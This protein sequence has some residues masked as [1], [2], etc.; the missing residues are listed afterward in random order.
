[1]TDYWKP[2]ISRLLW[3][4]MAGL[5]LAVMS[6]YWLPS[7][8]LVMAGYIGWTLFKLRQL[9]RWLTHGQKAEE[10]PDSDGAWEQ[11]AYLIHKAQQKSS[12]RK[13]QQMD[14]LMRFNNVL[15]ALP[16][17]A[18][19]LDDQNHIQWV[20][21]SASLL[22]GIHEK[23]D[24]QQRI[25]NLLRHPE[26]HKGLAE[27][28]EREIRFTAP[29]DENITLMAR[30]LPVQSGLRLL[31]VRDIS[32]SI[33]LQK[34]RKAFIAN[35]SHELRTPLT[36][37]VGYLELF[38]SEPGLPATLLPALQQSQEQAARMQ[39]IIS[40]MLELSRLEN[41]E[42]CTL[43]GKPVDVAN[44]LDRQVQA[45]RDTL[46]SATH[47][48]VTCINPNLVISGVEK[49]INSVITNLVTNAVRHTPAGTRVRIEWQLKKSGHACLLVEDDGPGI[50]REHL[51]HLT[52][53]FYRVDTGRSRASG[54]TGLGLAIVKHVMQCHQGYLTVRSK[55]GHTCFQAC[56]PPTRVMANP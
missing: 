9:Q 22:L 30:I 32:Q 11:I 54:G 20:N 55:P 29:R 35:A 45:I 33:Q 18:V 27:N 51:P 10:M 16:D 13:K 19:L 39:Q 8:L 24:L 47:T 31:N 21:K 50:P 4:M 43:N 46:A 56:F 52:E 23:M 36:V 15:S 26:L 28:T 49:D 44:L 38:A 41:Q 2:E 42:T 7:L 12:H 3:V 14:L 37:L 17:A 53:R 40:D 48:L 5:L 6:G 1:M 25:D 34:T